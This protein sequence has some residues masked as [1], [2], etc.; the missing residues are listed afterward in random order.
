MPK[1]TKNKIDERIPRSKNLYSPIFRVLK[2]LGGSGTNDEIYDNLVKDLQL[3]TEVLDILHTG[4]T[5]KSEVQN[6]TEW[7]RTFLKKAGIITNSSRSVWSITKEFANVDS[8]KNEDVTT[9][10]KKLE[11]KLGQKVEEADVETEVSSVM[12]SD[13]QTWR[14]KLSDILSK[15]DPY[16]F[17]RLAQ[18]VLRECGFDQVVVTKKSKDGGID[19]TGKLKINGIF[20]FNIAFQCKRYKGLVGA[21]EV[22][23]FRGSLSTDIEKGVMITTSSF[24]KDA[25]E[26][27]C[28]HG[29]KQIDL[30]DGEDLINKIAELKIGVKEIKSYEIDEEFFAKI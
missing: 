27:A 4:S 22:R 7:A 11:T 26:E 9:L 1:K 23:D 17:E 18:R 21:S 20:T 5:Y 10:I 3:P 14:E 16:G 6:Q 25:K 19:G 12:T 28:Q 2:K 8:I 29:K 30:L 13:A 15:M 24:S